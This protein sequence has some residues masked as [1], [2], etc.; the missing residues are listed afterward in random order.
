MEAPLE[1]TDHYGLSIMQE[2]SA[3]LGGQLTVGQRG[4]GGTRLQLLFSPKRLP[5]EA[6]FETAA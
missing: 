4:G 1:S 3:L 2:R 5:A 6:S